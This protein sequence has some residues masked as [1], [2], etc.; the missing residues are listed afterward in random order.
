MY[1][2][3]FVIISIILLAG[4]TDRERSIVEH[5]CEFI[6][7]EKLMSAVN[8][9]VKFGNPMSDEEGEDLVSQCEQ[10][11]K[12]MMCPRKQVYIEYYRFT[13]DRYSER[14]IEGK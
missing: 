13:Y 8:S 2:L 1:K 5:R 10:T 3:L 6:K 4:C 7:V 12:Q 14:V 9:C 11:V